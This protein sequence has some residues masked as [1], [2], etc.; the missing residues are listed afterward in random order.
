MQSVSHRAL[1]RSIIATLIRLLFNWDLGQKV[2]LHC[3]LVKVNVVSENTQ[4]WATVSLLTVWLSYSLEYSFHFFLLPL[5][6][7]IFSQPPRLG[8]R[9][10]SVIQHLSTA[11]SHVGWL[12]ATTLLNKHL[13]HA[14]YNFSAHPSKAVSPSER[15]QASGLGFY[16]KCLMNSRDL[17]PHR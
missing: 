6:G 3:S 4:S 14:S 10:L 8:R 13:L 1:P 9:L 11:S 5:S 17:Y 12:S 2:M 15:G 16:H 7:T